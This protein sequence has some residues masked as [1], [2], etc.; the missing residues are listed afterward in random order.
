MF[1][2]IEEGIGR[3][4]RSDE[5]RY[6]IVRFFVDEEDEVIEEDVSLEEA[7]EHCKREDTHGDGWF[8]GYRAR[9]N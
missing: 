6:D 1:D 7:Q 2:D 3:I 4:G 9:S 5:D 8:D